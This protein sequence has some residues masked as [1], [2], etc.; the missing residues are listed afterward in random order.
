MFVD[1][2]PMTSTT[3]RWKLGPPRL[4][5]C[6]NP[7]RPH[8]KEIP[9]PGGTRSVVYVCVIFH[10]VVVF[11]YLMVFGCDVCWWWFADS[12][13]NMFDM[14]LKVLGIL[15]CLF[16]LLQYLLFSVFVQCCF[17]CSWCQLRDDS[18]G[19]LKGLVQLWIRKCQPYSLLKLVINSERTQHLCWGMD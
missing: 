18:L 7:A 3:L 12:Y 15:L 14:I 11:E 9:W 4:R 19:K 5:G 16:L 10:A 8:G 17:F 6:G 1:V 13:W 2:S